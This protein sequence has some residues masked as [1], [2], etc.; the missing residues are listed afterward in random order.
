MFSYHVPV[1]EN[2]S[3]VLWTC[4]HSGFGW[5]W[6]HGT[7]WHLPLCTLIFGCVCVLVTHLLEV[8]SRSRSQQT[9]G[10]NTGQLPVFVN[11]FVFWNTAMLVYLWLVYDCYIIELNS[12]LQS[13]KC[14]LS[15]PAGKLF[16]NFWSS[17]L[18]EFNEFSE[19][20]HTPLCPQPTM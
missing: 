17:G 3:F 16:V 19:F 8:K 1:K 4:S 2:M 6:L 11:N 12:C 20:K 9:V 5:C 7:I 10:Q 18:N 14:L 13:W 15:A